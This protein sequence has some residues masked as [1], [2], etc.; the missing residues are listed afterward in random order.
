MIRLKHLLAEWTGET[1]SSC[2]QW[3]SQRSKYLGSEE[4][5]YVGIELSTTQFQLI[6]IGPDTGLSLAHANKGTGD[7]LHQLFNVL[8]CEINPWL[9]DNKIRPNIADIETQCI[10]QDKVFELII[11]VPLEPSDR[12][13]QM[14]HRGSWGGVPSINLIKSASPDVP[15]RELH[16]DTVVI[17][18]DGG[19]IITHFATYPLQ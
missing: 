9:A 15:E 2:R 1:W 10:A 18:N 8:I 12:A 19:K 11:Q 6:Y 16:T 3:A 5:V 17:P 7:T 14:N 4:G 13:W